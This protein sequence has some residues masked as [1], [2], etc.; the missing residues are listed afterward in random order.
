MRGAFSPCAT[1]PDQIRPKGFGGAIRHYPLASLFMLTS[2]NLA[3]RLETTA[4]A[5]APVLAATYVAGFM[6]GRYVHK[7][8]AQLGSLAASLS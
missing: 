1:Q 2:F 4:R 3:S 7:L 6:L 5:I 8:S